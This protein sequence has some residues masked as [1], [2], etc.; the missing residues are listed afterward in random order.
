MKNDPV[1]VPLFK[2]ANLA[3]KKVYNSLPSTIASYQK[4]RD[5]AGYKLHIVT[6]A[7]R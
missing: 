1:K 2:A 5:G 4:Y 6:D 7:L 3:K